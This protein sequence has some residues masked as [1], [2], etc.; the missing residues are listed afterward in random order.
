MNNYN[1]LLSNLKIPRYTGPN[2]RSFFGIAL[3]GLGL[4]GIY[5]SIFTVE[6]GHRA[7]VFSKIFGVKPEVY[8]EG[9]HF[10]V[11]YIDRPIDYNV[12]SKPTSIGSPTPSKDLQ[13]VNITI[14]VLSKPITQKLP[15][16]YR[17]MGIDY[18]QRVLPSIVNEVCKSVVAQFNAV[19][20]VSEREKISKTIRDRLTER[21]TEFYITLDDVSITHL[22]F[23]KEYAAAVE[24]KLVAQQAAER[25]KYVVDK[26]EQEKRGVIIRAEGEAVSA[27][28]ISDAIKQDPNFIYLR[29]LEA[30]RDISKL[31]AKGGNKVYL[32]ADNLLL[33]ILGSTLAPAQDTKA[34]K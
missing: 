2:P 20:L 19:Q 25:A 28:L 9:M 23:G 5:G 11:P 7:V 29:Q 30:A 18:D 8:G 24:A 10:K 34:K 33:N 13:M 26:A 1:N 27:K 31:I 22:S 4:A 14:R 6:G 17:T 15:E 21:A 3:A 12:R 32:E 16:I